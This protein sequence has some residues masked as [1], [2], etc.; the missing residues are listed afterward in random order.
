MR[1][2]SRRAL[3]FLVTAALGLLGLPMFAPSASAAATPTFKQVR[4]KEITSGTL[5]SLAFS[6]ANTTGNLI[7]V[8]LMW[9]NTDSVS[10]TDTRGNAYTS[11]GSRTMWGANSNN[12]S[13]VFYAKNVAA[14]SNTVRASF[15][16]AISSSADM[17]I[18]EYSGID[19]ADPLDVSAVNRGTAAAMNSGSATTSNA[20]D[21]I[22]GAGASASA[23]NQSGSGFTSRSTRFGNRTEDKNV[24]SAGPYNATANQNGNAWVMHMAAFKADPGTPDTTPPSK[25]TGLTATPTSTSQINLNWN[26]STDDVGVTGYKVF[27]NGTQ[28]ATPT[29][30]AYND[31][32]LTAS[33]AYAYEVS[34]T[35]A[36]GNNSPK[37]DVVSATT[38]T[39]APD[40]TPPTVSLTAPANGATVSGTITVTANAADSVGVVGVQFLV[41]G[42]NLGAEDTTSPYS[43]SWDTST[44][45]NGAHVLTARARDAANN[46][47]TSAA[48]NVTV[49]APD[50]AAPSVVITS[51]ANNAQ[52]VDIVSVTADA[53]DNVGVAGVQFLVDGVNSGVED[54]TAPYVLAW[55]SR[56]VSNG[57]HA[58]TARARDAAG[59]TRL[60]TAV[61]VNVA[62]T[63]QFQN[64]VLATGFDLPTSIEFLPDGRMLVVE[65]NGL[66]KV[67]SPPYTQVS[68]TPFLQI[69]NIANT[70]VQQGIF[71][72][73]LD[74]NF[75]SNHYYYVFYTANTPNRDRLSRFTA[76][77]SLTGTVAGSE[78]IL[79]EDPQ[80][81]NDEHHGGAVF[82]DNAGK[83]FFTTGD[84]F[85]GT[86]SQQLTSP[87]GKV[88]RINSDGTVPTDNPFYDG[89]GPNVD[90]IWALGLRNPFRASYDSVTDRIYIGDVGGNDPQTAKEEVNLG[91]RGANYG[92]PNSEGNCS[93]PCTSPIY[94][95]P[96]NG[97][98]AAITAG[99]VYR[100]SQYP[101]SFQG[102]FFY[103]DYGQNWI[104]RLTFD[105]S[106]NVTGSVNFEP[107]NGAADGPYGDIVYLTE[108]PD[109]A[110]YYV[111]LGYSDDSAQFG[112]SKIRRIRY[113]QSNQAPVSIAAGNPT[114]GTAPLDVTF[115]SAGSSDPEGQPLTY[116]W[117]FGDNTTSTQANP[118]HTYAQPG[119]Y[120]ARLTVSDGVNN[121]VSTGVNITVGSAPT[122][123]I[124]SPTDGIHFVAND[125]ISYSGDGVDPDDGA[126]P[127]SAFSWNIDFLHEGHV[128]P[129][130]PITGIKSGTF[131]IPT[132]GHDFEGNTR[133][134]ISLTVTDSDGLKS[135][136]F[137]TI[138]PQ[139]VNLTFNTAPTGLTLYF[140]GIAKTAPFIADTLVG[141][142]HNV[143]AR[144]QTGS[145]STYT[146]ASWSDGG[147]QQHDVVVPNTDQSYT[148]SYTVSSAPVPITFKQLNYSTPQTDQSTVNT[149]F[150]GAQTAG[151]T[152]IIAIGWNT[153]TGTISTVTDTAGNAYSLAA[154]LTRGGG[155]LS[156]AIYYAKNIAAAPT[157]NTVKVTF[158]G[159]MKY[160]DVRITEYAGLT[161]PTL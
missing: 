144:N 11:I 153:A 27:R 50:T 142:R 131:T 24:T 23:V 12:S 86:P 109:G 107:A 70:G 56:G 40:T 9:T 132:S 68:P 105:A 90:S 155:N 112:V 157:G 34:A 16:T 19:K 92:W 87:R 91:A 124:L 39:P 22:F 76:N 43:V 128:H 147:A 84:H 140:D 60:S 123:T 148:A 127:A 101:S 58:L 13:Q 5:N 10:V 74:P 41:D 85:Q 130:T 28:I 59:N 37:S 152:N 65:L 67:M 2:W 48:R 122:A 3:A 108:G 134:R 46:S 18:H 120:T 78:L 104:K 145:G 75:T 82:F 106:G 1:P 25:P 158:S 69:A 47:T 49:A 98:D 95:Y 111:D 161:R 62:N 53:S 103:A 14:G 71:D 64:E 100:G 52:V 21:L 94:F 143:E 44:A 146:F 115:S 17:Y 129:G 125:V 110:I 83:L 35:D 89:S 149:A 137:V 160:V 113:V 114:T 151:N 57:A 96:H 80:N 126:L 6:S 88:H 61:T 73:A 154:P 7:V 141:F 102:S 97:R 133:Y 159:A 36:A 116:L 55:D 54:T 4:A 32:G 150:S 38:L 117:T 31:T 79:Y 15:A 66:I 20:N 119:M 8:Y 77:A 118:V 135:T 139:K 30:S 156:Q 26:A 121:T 72:V 51:P 136:S 93:A 63:N 45:T 29:S 138:Y 81:A 99:F 42:N 33:T